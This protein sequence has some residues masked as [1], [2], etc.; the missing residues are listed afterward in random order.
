MS[1]RVGVRCSITA[2]GCLQEAQCKPVRG[3]FEDI[4]PEYLIGLRQARIGRKCR[5]KRR[6]KKKPFNP[7]SPETSSFPDR[8]GRSIRS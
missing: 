7:P 3:G 2:T 8:R 4:Q 5:A 1:S 6:E